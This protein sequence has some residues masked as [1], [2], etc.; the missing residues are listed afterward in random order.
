[1]RRAPWIVTAALGLIVALTACTGGSSGSRHTLYDGIDE[2]AADSSAIVVG[3][4]SAQ[5]TEGDQ[6]VSSIV[7]EG[8]STNPHLAENLDG[9]PSTIEPD[10]VID[11]RQMSSDP[12]LTPGA[13]YA[14][15]LTPTMLP[16]DAASQ[17]FVT[18]AVAGIYVRD[19]DTFHR[20]AVDSGDTLP[21]TIEVAG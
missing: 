4:V 17:Y 2:L 8:S 7:V 9:G 12:L 14:L 11:V 16:G 3:S 5:R 15:F 1:M 21:E 18:G 6:T 10:D 13:E 20:V 19:G